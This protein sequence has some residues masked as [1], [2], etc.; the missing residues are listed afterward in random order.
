MVAEP[1]VISREQISEAFA[2]AKL[3][4]KV[5]EHAKRRTTLLHTVSYVG[6]WLALLVL[7][8]L[9]R[10][11]VTRRMLHT[12]PAPERT[13]ARVI[14]EVNQMQ[15]D[16][17]QQQQSAARPAKEYFPKPGSGKQSLHVI[18][19]EENQPRKAGWLPFSLL[20]GRGSGSGS[21]RSRAGSAAAAQDAVEQQPQEQQ[22]GGRKL[23]AGG[24]ARGQVL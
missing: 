18:T 11:S 13:F 20:G 21:V 12:T 17:S 22:Q 15:L 23:L 3:K 19:F 16:A 7:L 2:S 14:M 4:S 5:L 1:Q 9:V 8:E 24:G 10:L 6:R